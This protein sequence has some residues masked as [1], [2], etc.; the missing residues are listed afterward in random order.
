VKNKK[1]SLGLS[2]LSLLPHVNSR[3][4][5]TAE[6]TDEIPHLITFELT[7]LHLNVVRVY[8]LTARQKPEKLMVGYAGFVNDFISEMSSPVHK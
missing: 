8:S 7:T 5:Q 2:L 3:P 1:G 6:R 4:D